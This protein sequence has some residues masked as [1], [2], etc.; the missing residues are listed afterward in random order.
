[1]SSLVRGVITTAGLSVL[2]ATGLAVG[3]AERSEVTRAGPA[4]LTVSSVDELLRALARAD[5][6]VIRLAPGTYP[7][8]VIKGAKPARPVTI[9]SADPARPAVMTGVTVRD[10]SN[11]ALDGLVFG[12]LAAGQQYGVQ[13]LRSQDVAIRNSRISWPGGVP[14]RSVV[15]AIFVRTSERV[16]V[17]GNTIRDHWHAISFLDVVDM[18]IADNLLHHLRTDGVR[19]GGVDRI[20]IENNVIGSFH[21]EPG[22]HPDGIQLW[23]TNQPKPGRN[24]IVRGNLVWRGDGAVAQG[25]FIRDTFERM[26][27]QGVSVENNLLVGTM[28]NGIA[29]LGVADGRVAG[30]EVVAFPD[31][32]SWISLRKSDAVTL[33]G[34]TANLFTRNV[35]EIAPPRGNRLLAPARDRGLERIRMWL[36]RRPAMRARFDALLAASR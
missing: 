18:R 14:G 25:V 27:F 33:T 20:V 6:G 9:V 12:P 11:V 10:S 23:S 19:G 17:S 4:S 1:M 30:N 26:P 7:P 35:R 22:D 8:L 15:S 2:A 5:G 28:Y 3:P 29:L 36:E 21:P 31:M 13:L 32:K 24:I 16:E 34:N